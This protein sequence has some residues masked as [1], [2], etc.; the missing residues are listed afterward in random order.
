[1]RA[2][3][4]VFVGLLVLNLLAIP[5]S[6]VEGAPNEL[7]EGQHPLYILKE[8]VDVTSDWTTVQWVQ[9]PHVL[10]VRYNVK[11]GADAPEFQFSVSGL[12]VWVS[13]RSFDTTRV[14]IELEALTLRGDTTALIKI[15][16]G[17]IMYSKIEIDA[18]DSTTSDFI[19]IDKFLNNARAPMEFELDLSMFYNMASSTAHVEETVKELKRKVFTFY[20]PWYANPRGPSNWLFH[21]EDISTESIGSSTN[22]PL[23]GAYDSADENVILAHMA[24]AKQA[25]IDGFIS[26]WWGMDAFEDDKLSRILEMAEQMSFQISIYYETVRDISKDDIVD[27]LTYV[28]DSYA[29]SSAFLK[30]SGRPVIFVYA[31]SIYGRDPSF[32]LEVRRR[33][34]SSVGPIVLIGDTVDAEY[35]NVFNGFHTYILLGENVEDFYRGAIERLRVGL[36]LVEVDDAF[37][38]AFVGEE[39]T[40]HIKPISFTVIPGYDDTKIRSPGLKVD[41]RE[42]KTLANYW[43]TALEL[44]PHS[45]LITSWNEWHEGTEIEPSREYSFDYI[46]MTRQFIEEYKQTSIP[47]FE[48]SF[49]AIVESFVQYPD[50]TGNGSILLTVAET[51]ALYVNVSVSGEEG[52]SSLD[53]QGD[54]YTYLER[55]N[56]ASASILI[57]SIPSQCELDIDV[58]FEAESVKPLFN[59]SVTVYDPVGKFHELYRGQLRPVA[60]SSIIGSVSSGSLEIGE[61]IIV[62]GSLSPEQVDRTI[63]LSYTK[64]DSSTL[65]R[66]VTTAVDGS[67]SDTFKPNVAGTWSVKASWEGD[68][69]FEG[70]AS[71]VLSFN[72]EKTSSSISIQTSESHITEGES[73]KISGSLDP[74]VPGAEVSID[75]TKPNGSEFTRTSNIDSDGSF[76]DSYSPTEAGSWTVKASWEGD[77]IHISATSQE[78]SFTVEEKP[79]GGI[80][81]FRYELIIL[82]IVLGALMLWMLQRRQ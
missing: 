38:S 66:T 58:V 10:A 62:S 44:D 6:T 39:I 8:V 57:P 5:I 12:N 21:W 28:V 63:T 14:V 41:R 1:M 2:R 36:P 29:G 81:G 31:V 64:P 71:S 59:I 65:T 48:T 77:S 40:L 46:N 22:Y 7:T 61:S 25:G 30:D 26:S 69:E 72:V 53:L 19:N 78:I 17:H 4:L 73:I 50:F 42:G 15:D 82:G 34:E 55:K 3:Y 70:S 33:V 43:E 79:K 32:W 56:D 24:M 47:S 80:P 54:F 11:E 45:V 74:A 18:Y 27:E 60:Q 75:F 13:K 37:S 49:S 68:G 52:L 51:P 67:Y 9:G 35:S 20:Y 23:M 16:K 76:S